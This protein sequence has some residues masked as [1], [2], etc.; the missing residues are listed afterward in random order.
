MTKSRAELIQT[1]RH[2][3]SDGDDHDWAANML[4]RDAAE[5][6]AMRTAMNQPAEPIQTCPECMR[7]GGYHGEGCS[8]ILPAEPSETLMQD[9]RR[10]RER[11]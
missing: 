3:D 8:Q 5:I 4:E 6:N 7:V 11:L 2:G 9:L 1:L 10:D